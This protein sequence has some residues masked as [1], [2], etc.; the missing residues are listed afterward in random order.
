MASNDLKSSGEPQSKKTR[1]TA[2]LIQENGLHERDFQEWIFCPGMLFNAEGKWW[3]DYG[4]RRRPHEGL[5]LC[6]YRDRRGR[7]SRLGAETRV[8]VMY[9]GVVVGII[10]DFLGKS[11][12]VEHELPDSGNSRFC[13]IYGH[14]IPVSNL[15]VGTALKGGDVIAAI[16]DPVES[17]V[18]MAPHL[19][20]TLGWPSR[21]L[22]YDRL[23]WETIGASDTLALFDPLSFIGWP[24]RI[25]DDAHPSCGRFRPGEILAET[26][27]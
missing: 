22:S 24:H 3:G 19:H 25:L 10:N 16:A 1:F 2:F 11:I 26:A 8:P 18:D 20:V 17:N 12:V 4:R 7:I 23:N 21:S 5:D 27:L 6:L 9:T 14:T 13:A 15:A